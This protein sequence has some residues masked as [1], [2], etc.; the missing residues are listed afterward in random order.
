MGKVNSH[1]MRNF[2][3][4]KVIGFSNILGEA[5]IDTTPKIWEKRIKHRDIPYYSL[6]RRFTVDENPCNSHRLGITNSHKMEIF[7]GK[8]YHSED[9]GFSGN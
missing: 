1:N 8:P 9:V 6:P 2:S 3:H 4:L 5:E 7:C